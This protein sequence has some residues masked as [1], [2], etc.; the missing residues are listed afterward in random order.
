MNDNISLNMQ[1]ESFETR[2]GI[3]GQ[4]TDIT[5]FAGGEGG[6]IYEMGCPS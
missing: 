6:V 3:S 4:E 2:K 5:I 1:H